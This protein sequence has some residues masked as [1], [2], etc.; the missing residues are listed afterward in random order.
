[1]PR[2]TL[3]SV[4]WLSQTDSNGQRIGEWCTKGSDGYSG[5]C[6]FCDKNIKIG[7]KGKMSLLK[8]SS[9]S[10]HIDAVKNSIDPN[11]AKLFA[12]SSQ[13]PKQSPQSTTS[14][15]LGL[16]F[17]RDETL[18]AEILW[19]TKTACGNFSLRSTDKIGDLFRE[20]FPDS[21]IAS[22]FSLSRTSASYM[23]SEGL[24][25]Y[26]TKKMIQD[27][28]KS[29][30]PFS[31]HFDETTNTQVKKQ[32]DLILRYWSP[33][34]EEVWIA[35]YTSLFFGHAE[36]DKVAQ[37]MF[38]KLMNDQIP[39][40]RMASLIR[41]GPNVNKTIF[42]C[43]NE[44]IMEVYPEYPG[45]IELGSCSIHI[46]HNAFG[47]GLGQ[48]GK[49]IDQLCL[50]LHSLFKYSAARREDFR[51]VQTELELVPSNFQ[52]HT[53]VRW[54]SLGPAINRIL[55]QWDGIM[56]FV[57]ELSKDQKKTP[58][59]S[60]FK[61]IYSLLGTNDKG[62]TKACLEFLSDVVPVFEQ[63]LLIFHKNSP[64]V[65]ILYDT[66]CE[67]LLKLLRRFMKPDAVEGKYGSELVT[68]DCKDIKLRL[69]EDDLVIGTRTRKALKKLTLGQQERFIL[70]VRSFY[71]T[72]A[73][74][75]QDK[76]P[77]K[78]SF[79]QQLGCLNILRIYVY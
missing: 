25:P 22:N 39:V 44:M 74:K 21:K 60:S 20:M 32:V 26:F 50:D 7:N 31:L 1:M 24:S 67:S 38:E 23:I 47:D 46:V 79:L 66:L 35:Y 62:M 61:R 15:G 71:G 34:H 49:E 9:S 18:K 70:G 2:K 12:K 11:Q 54:L 76:L 52:Q 69:Q 16:I 10:R 58:K 55:E 77:L 27:L 73:S 57:T 56:Q 63:V 13:L 30:L 48:F 14:Q 6:K 8:H 3:F 53:E 68:I 51:K 36:G 64:V 29:N 5:D 43:L 19:L 28:V 65:H 17:H 72:A 37:K 78:N 59:S 45:L 41:D 33:T 75:L 40:N 4:A 42:R